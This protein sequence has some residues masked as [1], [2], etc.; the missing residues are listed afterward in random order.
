MGVWTAAHGCHG[1]GG[2]RLHEE[3]MNSL[4]AQI[5]KIIKRKLTVL[6]ISLPVPVIFI[7]RAQ[8][9][10][11]VKQSKELKKVNLTGLQLFRSSRVGG[12]L[13]FTQHRNV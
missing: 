7:N 5:K 9:C 1:D 8:N 4:R 2:G 10:M 3:T 11:G 12:R 13:A 6:T